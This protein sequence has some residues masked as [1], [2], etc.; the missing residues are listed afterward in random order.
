MIQLSDPNWRPAIAQFAK[1]YVS[2]RIMMNMDV[3]KG[4]KE[5]AYFGKISQGIVDFIT[6]HSTLIYHHRFPYDR[7]FIVHLKSND[8]HPSKTQAEHQQWLR[9]GN[10]YV[11]VNPD[12]PAVQAAIKEALA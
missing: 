8:K 1:D 4:V 3:E 7:D 6:A 5:F 12:S 10:I 9:D 2:S 11:G